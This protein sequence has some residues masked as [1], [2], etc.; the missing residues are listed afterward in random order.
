MFNI[1]QRIKYVLKREVVILMYHRIADPAIDPWQLAVSAENF[2]QH[3]KLLERKHIVKP[4]HQIIEDLK[5]KKISKKSI[6]I[7][8]D[9]GYEDN[10]LIAKPLLE[11][12]KLPATFFIASKNISSANEFWW[13]ELAQILLQAQKLPQILSLDINDHAFSFDLGEE[14]LLTKELVNKHKNYV[15]LHPAETLRSRLYHK[16]WKYL[17]AMPD[18]NQV[19]LMEQ[20][21]KW[22]GVAQNSQPAYHCLSAEQIKEL[23]ACQLFN[24]GGHT[25]SHPV[26]PF[27][28]EDIQQKEIVG[29]KL[30]LEQITEKKIDLF[31]YPSGKY[32]DL[33][34]KILNQMGFEAAFTT[35]AKKVKKYAN[36][37]TLGRFQVTNYSGDQLKHQLLNWFAQ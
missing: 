10:Y 15:Y 11:K 2:E 34:I 32:N 7:T 26:L 17:S 8:F 3:L 5:K 35:N 29:N 25:D 4:L 37:F 9:D 14:T 16:L 19:K 22:A 20:I 33:T 23:S 6:A 21:R 28:N 27:Y 12:Y 1:K 30:L 13:D 36:P 31:A 24:I 18:R